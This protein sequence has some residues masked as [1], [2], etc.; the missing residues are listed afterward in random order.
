[1]QHEHLELW[2]EYRAS[3]SDELRNDLIEIYMPTVVMHARR[4]ST[5]LPAS[6]DVDDLVSEGTFGLV[7]A[8]DAFDLG[9]GIRFKTYCALR[10]TGAM[11]DSLR[12]SDWVPRLVRNNQRK[13][14]RE[15]EKFFE[16]MNRRPTL[17]EVADMLRVDESEIQKMITGQNQSLDHVIDMGPDRDISVAQMLA[18]PKEDRSLDTLRFICRSLNKRER[19][20]IIMYYWMD[21]TQ[22]QIGESLGLSES[23]VSQM[24]SRLLARLRNEPRIHEEFA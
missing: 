3:P 22:K 24:H 21:I 23:R 16:R 4:L 14:Q 7:Q 13:L 5:T 2:Q 15:S 1:M 6:S 8:I 20:L 9:R 18:A 11:K 19:L 10:V 12:Q 17:S